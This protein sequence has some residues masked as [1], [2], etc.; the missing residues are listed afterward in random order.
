[1]PADVAIASDE[2]IVRLPRRA[3]LPILLASLLLET[4]VRVP[5]WDNRPLRFIS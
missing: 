3:H 1:M 5:W 4:P 2:V